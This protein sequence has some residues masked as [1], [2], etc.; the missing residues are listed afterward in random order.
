M[1]GASDDAQSLIVYDTVDNTVLDALKNDPEYFYKFL[2]AFDGPDAVDEQV[3]LTLGALLLGDTQY[4][5]DL[6]KQRNV[7]LLTDVLLPRIHEISVS[8][9][10]S[11]LV[12]YPFDLGCS[13]FSS[14]RIVHE[15]EAMEQVHQPLQDWF[16]SADCAELFFSVFDSSKPFTATRQKQQGETSKI[17]ESLLFPYSAWN[18]DFKDYSLYCVPIYFVETFLSPEY[19]TQ[20]VDFIFAGTPILAQLKYSLP[21]LLYLISYRTNKDTVDKTTSDFLSP[22]PNDSVSQQIAKHLPTILSLLLKPVC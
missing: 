21:T 16:S 11:V 8:N 2:S 5:L 15:E 13:R 12:Q 22:M 4:V 14:P 1:F 17:I 6:C 18:G 10:I 9:L 7:N 20:F 19:L 3:V